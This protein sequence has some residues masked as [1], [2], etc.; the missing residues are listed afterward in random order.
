MQKPRL[1]AFTL[2][3]MLV[4]IAIIATLAALLF[5]AVSGMQERGKATQDLSNLRQVGMATQ[6][7]LNDNDG[8]FFPATDVWM[9]DLVPKYL[10]SWKILK[11]PFDNRVL[12]ET[13]AIA[14]VSY[15]LNAAI[16]RAAPPLAADQISNPSVCI[17]LAPAQDGEAVTRFTGLGGTAVTVD[18]AGGGSQGTAIG[19]THSSRK[20]INACMADLHVETMSWGTANASGYVNDQSTPS[21]QSGNQR[22][23]PTAAPAAP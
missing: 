19:G 16:Q 13:Q 8:A 15:G 9:A 12:S 5:P 17:L 14:P 3:E 23:N 4:V 1:S 21:D 11:S 22:W 2:I 18:R 7:Y 6:M 20:R 10:G